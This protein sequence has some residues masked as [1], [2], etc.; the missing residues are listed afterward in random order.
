MHSSVS[1]NLLLIPSKV[2]FISVIVFFSSGCFFY[3]FFSYLLKF[4]L[5]SSS[6]FL[7]SV[8]IL[9]T[10]VL[11][12]LSGNYLCFIRGFFSV[13]FPPRS[14]IWNMSL[15]LFILF[16]FLCLC[17][18]RWNIY[19]SQ[20]SRCALVWEY[21]YAI[22]LCTVAL[23]E[24]LDLKWAWAASFPGVCWQPPP[25]WEVGLESEGLEPK[26]VASQDFS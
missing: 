13:I 8:S 23:V 21:L 5:C 15:C 4:S 6:L 25:W 7:T 14:L 9:I 19:P 20:S 22:C 12:S 18:I 11:N 16:N 2:F 3:I 10:I 24:E 26:P 1:P 17:E